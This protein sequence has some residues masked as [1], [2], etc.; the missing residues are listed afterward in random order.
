MTNKGPT[1]EFDYIIVGGGAAGCVLANRLTED[2]SI[3][4]CL[5]E[6]GPPDRHLM[7]RIPGGVVK[8]LFNPKLT[9]QFQTEPSVG[10]A[11]RSV[12]APQ[13]RTLGGSS[14]INGMIYNRGQPFDFDSWAQAGNLGWGFSD[15]LPYFKRSERRI[16]GEDNEFRG[17]SGNLPVTDHDWH[18]PFVDAFIAG[19]MGLGIP[20]N[21]DYNGASQAGVGYQ[22]RFIYRGRRHSAAHAF[23]APCRGRPG[24][25]VRC[26]ALAARIL[27]QSKRAVG[28]AYYDGATKTGGGVLREVRARREVI[29]TAGPIN[30]PKLLQLSGIGAAGLLKDCGVVS[31]HDLPGVGE[32]LQDHY[33]ARGV[34]RIKNSRTANDLSRWPFVGWEILKWLANKP[35][36]VGISASIANVFWKSDD[37]LDRPDLQFVLTPISFKAGQFGV[38]EDFPGMTLG[39]WPHRPQSRGWVRI[40]SSNAFD[41]PTLQ[42]NYLS[43]AYDQRALVAGLKLVRRFL[44]T[45]ELAHYVDRETAPGPDV[46]TDDQLLDFAR[47]NG[48]TIYHFV[49][50]CR[51]GPAT[52]PM[53]VVGSD[54]KVHGVACLRVADSSIMP[55]LPS[56][57]TFASTLAIAEKASDMIKSIRA[58]K[59]D[60]QN[61]A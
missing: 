28:V 57:N 39:V 55:N 14:A 2:S 8:I 36:I 44:S 46:V 18:M 35:S 19:V 24:L 1:E 59:S 22:Q 25:E 54:L 51:M 42:P 11:D 15:L 45:P 32:N 6:A 21:P 49:G 31:V 5:L 48:S 23:L 40:K 17:R 10:T 41:P 9:W 7:I 27:M 34:V 47:H 61:A 38:L 52:D 56:A 30:S 60:Q 53:A 43:A 50:A 20:R 12:Y 3:T 16:G 26:N 37:V 29:V 13:G 4:V 58:D 33:G